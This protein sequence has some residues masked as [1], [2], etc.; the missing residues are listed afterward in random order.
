MLLRD[1]HGELPIRDI[2]FWVLNPGSTA[3]LPSGA[4]RQPAPPT[5]DIGAA[6]STTA[7]R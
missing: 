7:A 2:A 5:R 3:A 1:L 4:E 6:D